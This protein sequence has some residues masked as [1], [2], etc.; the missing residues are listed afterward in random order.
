MANFLVIKF[1]S[2]K[3]IKDYSSIIKYFRTTFQNF[4]E[5]KNKKMYFMKIPVETCFDY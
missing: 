3:N 1:T 4:L 5:K 2:Y